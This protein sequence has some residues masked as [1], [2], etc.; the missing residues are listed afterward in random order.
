MAEW[1]ERNTLI[2]LGYVRLSLFF[3]TVMAELTWWFSTHV[4]PSAYSGATYTVFKTGTR[5]NGTH[6]QLTA[7]CT[8]CTDY[9]GTVLSPTSSHRL[10]F[11]YC[12]TR[13]AS[14]SSSM[15]SITVHDVHDYWNHDF[16]TGQNPSFA[17]LVTKNQ[18]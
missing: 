5:V 1:A 17:Q 10:A 4:T 2:P 7:K 14:P 16:S 8:G 3:M 11:A 12:A 6:W 15:S 9:K 18:A 13:P